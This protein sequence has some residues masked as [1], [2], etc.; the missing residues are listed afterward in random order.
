MILLDLQKAFDTVSHSILLTKLQTIG[1][2]GSTVNR[3]SSYLSDRQQ[4]VDVSE[5]FT[6][7]AKIECGV[8]RG[9]YWALSSF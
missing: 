9:P 7:E 6:S 8:P 4:L 2:S 3:F 5:T 1:L